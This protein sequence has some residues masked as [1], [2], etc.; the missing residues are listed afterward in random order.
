MQSHDAKILANSGTERR[1]ATIRGK[2]VVAV[3]I[4]TGDIQHGCNAAKR[5]EVGSRLSMW[6]VVESLPV[7]IIIQSGVSQDEGSEGDNGM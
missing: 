2:W 6:W 4:T 5:W 7:G 3:D 1:S